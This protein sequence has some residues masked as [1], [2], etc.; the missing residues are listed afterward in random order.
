MVLKVIF[1]VL[2]NNFIYWVIDNLKK[3]TFW[4]CTL[5]KAKWTKIISGMKIEWYGLHWSLIACFWLRNGL[6]VYCDSLYM[7]N[8]FFKY[9]FLIV[10]RFEIWWTST[11]KTFVQMFFDHQF[12]FWK[13]HKNLIMSSLDPH[14]WNMWT[15]H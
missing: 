11:I 12:L 3:C 15:N 14:Y 6:I 2:R 4:L 5:N 1:W 13:F 9:I 10:F 7:V 8:L